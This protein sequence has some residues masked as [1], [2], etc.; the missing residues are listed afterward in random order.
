LDVLSAVDAVADSTP[1]RSTAVWFD[2]FAAVR[3]AEGLEIIARPV[4]ARRAFD[5]DWQTQMYQLGVRYE[6]RGTRASDLGVRVEVGQMPSPIGIAMLENRAD[7]NPVI[8]QHSAYY[9]PL[10]RVDP[11]I[12]RSYLIAGSYPFGVQLTVSS[13]WWDA[14]VAAIDSSPVRGRPLLGDGNPPRLLNGVAGIGFSPRVGLRFGGGFAYGPYA[15]VAEVR[16]RSKG[17]R[18]ATM[19]QVEGEWSF[20]YTRIVGELVRSV[21]ETSRAD[22]RAMGGWIEATQ[23]LS[24]RVFVA[25]RFDSQR[26]DYQRPVFQDFAYQRYN[27]VEAVLGLRLTPDVTLRGGYLA[28]EGYVVSHWDDQAI[29]SIVWQRKLW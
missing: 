20:G 16:D 21:F 14:R 9:V 24:P 10:P 19:I 4:I 1:P 26:L 25:G 5:G 17:D 28:R 18:Q 8:S 22:A 27:R 2:I 6:L 29:G 15:S 3:L 11:E 7:L 23:T 13:G 12:P